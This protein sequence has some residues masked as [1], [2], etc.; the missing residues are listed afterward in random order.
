MLNYNPR[1]LLIFWFRLV[2][3][4][5]VKGL[6]IIWLPVDFIRN[7]GLVST[8]CQS[9]ALLDH[10]TNY[11]WKSFKKI[12][13]DEQLMSLLFKSYKSQDFLSPGKLNY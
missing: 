11:R 10:N 12:N 1:S 13:M 5:T 8:Y 6:Q 3:K 7:S 4:S 2:T 9:F